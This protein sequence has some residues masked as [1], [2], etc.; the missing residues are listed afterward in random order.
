MNFVNNSCRRNVLLILND[1]RHIVVGTNDLSTNPDSLLVAN[2]TP[3]S[4]F[5]DMK[6]DISQEACIQDFVTSL[7]Y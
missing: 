3:Q 6:C 4:I 1:R 5:G 2:V 7:S